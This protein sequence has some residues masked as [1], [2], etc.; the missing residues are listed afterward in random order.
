MNYNKFNTSLTP[1]RSQ[2]PTL[3]LSL[4]QIIPKSIEK[5]KK[6]EREEYINRCLIFNHL[7]KRNVYF[8]VCP[9]R[10]ELTGHNSMS[11]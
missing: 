10:F 6:R 5:K 3:K 7:V 8:T 11:E 2:L 1:H 9:I 4:I